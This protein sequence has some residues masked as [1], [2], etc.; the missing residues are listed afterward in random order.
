MFCFGKNLLNSKCLFLHDACTRICTTFQAVWNA[1]FCCIPDIILC[2]AVGGAV[3]EA[4]VE[5]V[6]AGTSKSGIKK[7]QNEENEN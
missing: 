1:E 7:Q 5:A 3:V 2:S 4:V 6:V